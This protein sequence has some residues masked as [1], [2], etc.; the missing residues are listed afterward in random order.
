[1]MQKPFSQA[2]E[3]NQA[4]ITAVLEKI[5][6]E[7]REIL[8]IGTGTGQH[9]V[10]IAKHMPHLSWQ[11]SEQDDDFSGMQMWFDESKL[12][13]I[14][15]PLV[16]NVADQPWP[17]SQIEG[18]FTANTLHIMS[19]ENVIC[20]F[21]RLGQYLLP[22]CNFV[23]YGPFNKQGQYT[24]ESNALF[25]LRLKQQNPLSGIRHIE[26]LTVLGKENG[27]LLTDEIDMPANN[28]ILVWQSQGEQG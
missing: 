21:Q 2:C 10:Y 15:P 9:A 17:V 6:P 18:V 22:G 11:P 3:N 13:N 25:D 28:K 23:S 19:W 20:F 1:M 7:P 8:E 27:L 14:K 26:D 5:W 12:K 24:S 4:P 16:I